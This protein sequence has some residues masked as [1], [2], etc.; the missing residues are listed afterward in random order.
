MGLKHIIVSEITQTQQDQAMR[1]V[2]PYLYICL[3]NFGYNYITWSN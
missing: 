3:W 2:A 1:C